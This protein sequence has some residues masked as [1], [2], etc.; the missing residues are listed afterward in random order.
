MMARVA[1][2]PWHALAGRQQNLLQRSYTP[3]RELKG[4]RIRVVSTRASKRRQRK[5]PGL[6]VIDVTNGVICQEMLTWTV[7]QNT[8]FVS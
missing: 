5:I 7:F 2:T 3:K 6:S 8:G 4:R 1:R